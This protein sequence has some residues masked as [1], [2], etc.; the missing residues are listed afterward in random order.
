MTKQEFEKIIG[1]E[2][3]QEDYSIVDHVYTWHPSISN[4]E[5][6]D[7]IADLYKKF[8]MPIIKNMTEVANYMESLDKELRQARRVIEEIKDRTCKVANGDTE[9]ERCIADAKSLFPKISNRNEWGSMYACLRERYGA[10]QATEA[11]RI[12]NLKM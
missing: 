10:E 4:V 8:G 1:E 7:E 3:S 2:I 6:K 9:L 11:I 5:G 12:A